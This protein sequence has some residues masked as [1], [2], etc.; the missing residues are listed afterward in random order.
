MVSVKKHLPQITLFIKHNSLTAKHFRNN[1]NTNRNI[2]QI[3]SNS[4]QES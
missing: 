2:D 4:N 1:I 3:T